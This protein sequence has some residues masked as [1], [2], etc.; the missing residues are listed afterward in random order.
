[1]ELAL[2][3]LL[4]IVGL[5]FEIIAVLVWLGVVKPASSAQPQTLEGATPWDLL[6]ALLQKAPWTAVVGLLLIYAGLKL[7]G[8]DLPF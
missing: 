7:V 5:A 4:I 1:M 8:V 6:I 3:Y 2:G